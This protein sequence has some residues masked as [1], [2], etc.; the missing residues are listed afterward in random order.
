M[1][2]RSRTLTAVAVAALLAVTMVSPASAVQPVAGSVVSS[3]ADEETQFPDQQVTIKRDEYG[4]PHVYADSNYDLFYGYGY[5]LGEDRL[6]QMEMARRAVLGTSAEVLGSDYVDI[7]KQTRETFDPEAIHSQLDDLSEDELDILTGYADGMNRYIDEVQDEPE[8]LMPK[9]FND[10]DFSP[11]HWTAYDVA[12]IWIGTM[13]NRFS[14]ASNEVENLQVLQSLQDEHGQ[15]QGQQLFDQ[16]LWD[17][18]TN[19]P[20]TVPRDDT[21]NELPEV[22]AQN[23]AQPLA[24]ISSDVTDSGQELMAAQGA[25]GSLGS[26]PQA[27][28]VWLLGDE[29]TEDGGSIL[30]NGPQFDW[31]N[32]SYVYG[33]GLHG[34]GFDV[35]GNTPFGYPAVLFGTNKDISWGSTAGPLDVNDVYQEKLNPDNPH[36]YWYN[37][38]WHD[39]EERDETIEVQDG[40]DVSHTVYSTVHGTVTSFDEAENTAYAKKR[41]WT[42]EEVQSLMAWIGVA[43]AEN[44]DDYLS[45]AEDMAISINWYYADNEGNI[46][47]VSPGR[48]PDRPAAQ[49]PR[50]PAVG[51]GSMEWEGIRD[52]SDNPQVYNPEQGYIANWNNQA[53]P[54]AVGDSGNWAAVD[55]VHEILA[56][57]ES[58][59][60]FSTD[61][62]WDII[63]T[64]SYADLNIRYLREPLQ[65]ASRSQDLDED[66][67]SKIELLTD[68]D[69]QTRD[70]DEN[71]KIDDPQPEIMRTW[72]PILIETVL[73]DD[74]PADVY[75]TY[76]E[77]IYPEP[78]GSARPAS[79]VKLIYN[80][81]LGDDAGVEQTTDFFNG[82]DP[83]QVLVE[84]YLE[85]IDQLEEE[86]GRDPIAWQADVDEF[87]FHHQNFIGVDQAGEDEALTAP[88]YQNRG[89]ENDLIHLDGSEAMMCAAAPPGQSGFI[90]PTG[91]EDEHYQ[92]QLDLYLKFKCK[93]EHLTQ[94]SVEAAAQSTLTMDSRGAVN[95]AATNT[96]IGL[97]SLWWVGLGIVI[98]VGIVSIMALYWRRRQQS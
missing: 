82:Q 37:G 61:D 21:T 47:Y 70:D 62:A 98:P 39:M 55:R 30:V 52:F 58:Q 49:D 80:N 36:Q 1:P 67:Q 76:Q 65:Q 83:D 29:K 56:E 71:G 69:G 54:A 13:A 19:A 57:L 81:L 59:D 51:D 34:A 93:D 90:S 22:T 5:A 31:F 88:I 53:A 86:Y 89:T 40:D 35:T 42:G 41:S 10:H 32:P 27:S 14:N 16:I 73:A 63:E 75:E 45:Q 96:V 92:D 3:A 97:S 44:W 6:F 12:M 23:E 85:A 24:S 66:A 60:T 15:Q 7:D 17:E 25:D 72:L 46:G 26:M 77:D 50:L 87:E 91:E 28:N 84:T 2:S 43:K 18:D 79:G 20:T 95:A 11:Q 38:Q 48:L 94:D 78:G 8:R 64:T 4:V 9:Q 33:I 74:L 68:W